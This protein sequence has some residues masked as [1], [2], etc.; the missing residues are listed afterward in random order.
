[1]T[2]DLKLA[3]ER[4]VKTNQRK[5]DHAEVFTPSHIVEDMLDLVKEESDR[6]NSRVLE[7]ACGEGNFLKQVLRRSWEQS[8]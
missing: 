4:L 5:N 6:I 2:K 3:S 8:N 7:P 1:M